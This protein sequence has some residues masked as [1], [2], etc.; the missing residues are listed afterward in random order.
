M[1]KIVRKAAG[2]TVDA[3]PYTESLLLA[4]ISMLPKLKPLSVRYPAH[5]VLS[6]L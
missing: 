2:C 4:E 3:L 6:L 5:E 1:Q